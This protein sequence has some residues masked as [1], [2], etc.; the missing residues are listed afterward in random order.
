MT[1]IVHTKFYPFLSHSLT[2]SLFFSFDVSLE[3]WNRTLEYVQ[4]I[5]DVDWTWCIVWLVLY[6]KRIKLSSFDV[7]EHEHSYAQ[8]IV[9]HNI[10]IYFTFLFHFSL[11]LSISLSLFPINETQTSQL[12]FYLCD[13]WRH[14]CWIVLCVF[15]CDMIFL[16]LQSQDAWA[17]WMRCTSSSLSFAELCNIRICRRFKKWIVTTIQMSRTIDAREC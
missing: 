13:G 5:C 17:Y 3:M 14:R 4:F 15:V 8:N 11:S 2:F 12:F 10:L 9:T 1:H 6:R 16:H 7:C